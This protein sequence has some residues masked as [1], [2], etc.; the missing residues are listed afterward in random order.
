MPN[1]ISSLGEGPDACTASAPVPPPQWTSVDVGSAD[2]ST[3][4][5]VEQTLAAPATNVERRLQCRFG[6]KI[7]LPRVCHTV[8][9][10]TQGWLQAKCDM[11]VCA[12]ARS[13][14]AISLNNSILDCIFGGDGVLTDARPSDYADATCSKARATVWTILQVELRESI[15]GIQLNAEPSLKALVMS[16][17]MQFP[18]RSDTLYIIPIISHEGLSA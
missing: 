5:V 16:F 4:S 17:E 9:P 18:A 3:T 10:R 11:D 7:A 14:C 13:V 15:H 6:G 8:V 2:V 12:D 1:F